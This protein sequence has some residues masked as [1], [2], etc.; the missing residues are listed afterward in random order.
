MMKYNLKHHIVQCNMKDYD[1]L[2]DD[3]DKYDDFTATP[4]VLEKC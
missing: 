1:D 4:Q 3:D 2:Y